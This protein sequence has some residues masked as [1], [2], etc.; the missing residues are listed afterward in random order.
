MPLIFKRKPE[1]PRYPE[2]F[3]AYTKYSSCQK[4][5]VGD[6]CKEVYDTEIA[7]RIAVIGLEASHLDDEGL[8]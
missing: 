6:E 2:C 3:G 8:L 4:C 1:P 7:P 5:A